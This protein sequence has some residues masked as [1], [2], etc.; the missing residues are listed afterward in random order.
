MAE[1]MD[2]R[3][4]PTPEMLREDPQLA[5][6]LIKE[7]KIK[8]SELGVSD[9]MLRYLKN[10]QKKLSLEKAERLYKLIVLRLG[11]ETE[12][13]SW[14]RSSARIERRPAEPEVRGSNPRGPAT[15]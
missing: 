1:S 6:R 11:I 4:V 7:F 9:R 10:G 14:A 2:L 12:A 13:K 3:D 5:Y 15:Q 8:T